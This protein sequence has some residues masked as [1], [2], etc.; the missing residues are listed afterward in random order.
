VGRDGC[1]G[2]LRWWYFGYGWC[3]RGCCFWVFRGACGGGGVL[4]PLTFRI[5]CLTWSSVLSSHIIFSWIRPDPVGF[6]TIIISPL[7]YIYRPHRRASR[8]VSALLEYSAADRNKLHLIYPLFRRI[9]VYSNRR[10][11]FDAQSMARRYSPFGVATLLHPV[12]TEKS[13]PSCYVS[14]WCQSSTFPLYLR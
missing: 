6:F 1:V 8:Y 9:A 5:S 12:S 10:A 13:F 4:V 2:C 3:G 7:S 11:D 14:N